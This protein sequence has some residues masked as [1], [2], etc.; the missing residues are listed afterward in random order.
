[1]LDVAI[2]R[3]LK[4]L[5]T[6]LC[7][8]LVPQSGVRAERGLQLAAV[9]ALRGVI[10]ACR[11]RME[12]YRKDIVAAV[13]KCWIQTIDEGTEAFSASVQI[14]MFLRSRSHATFKAQDW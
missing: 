3:Y 12:G 1:M 14:G 11:E 9:K 13:A 4:P 8:S 7:Y 5:V 10:S 6:Q 2:V